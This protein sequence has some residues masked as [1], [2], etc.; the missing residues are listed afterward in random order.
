MSAQDDV[1]ENK[2]IDLF[3]L[4][5]PPNYVR[6]GTDAVLHYQGHILEFELKSVTTAGGSLSTVRDFGPDHIAKWKDKHWIVGIYSGVTLIRCLYGSPADMAS[7]IEEKWNY[8]KADFE[9]AQQVP[10]LITP[11]VMYSILGE[12]A[13]YSAADAKR[14]HKAQYSSARYKELM[15]LTEPGGKGKMKKVGY[16]PNRMLQILKDR[17]KYVIE[18]GATLNNPHIPASYIANWKEITEDH[19]IRLREFVKAWVDANQPQAHVP[20]QVQHDTP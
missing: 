3:N 17:A 10:E 1:R 19:A 12:K 20:L 5:R 2:I 4:R 16:S 7:W 8:I 11:S 9:L 15:D 14:L 13:V 18:R 6:H